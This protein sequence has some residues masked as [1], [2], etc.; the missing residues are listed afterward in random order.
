MEPVSEVHAR[1]TWPRAFN[2]ACPTEISSLVT[3]SQL[4]CTVLYWRW[5]TYNQP[6][7]NQVN[8]QITRILLIKELCVWWAVGAT[9]CYNWTTFEGEPPRV[10]GSINVLN[11]Q[12][13]ELLRCDHLMWT[14]PRQAEDWEWAEV[15][16]REYPWHSY[17]LS[18][19]TCSAS[20][21]WICPR[22]VVFSAMSRYWACGAQP[23]CPLTWDLPT[24][25]CTPSFSP[26]ERAG[27][28]V[29]IN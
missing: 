22:P 23:C 24:P 4:W 8:L 3:G 27:I 11:I 28:H 2:E 21:T 9:I 16:D 12:T 7:W 29:G 20:S 13:F 19:P 18:C 14:A 1:S 5:P 17:H 25:H 26:I 15:K 6:R 10:Q